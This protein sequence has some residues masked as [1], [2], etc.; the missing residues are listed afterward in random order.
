MGGDKRNEEKRDVL[1]GSLAK[2]GIAALV[3]SRSLTFTIII[4]S[5]VGAIVSAAFFFFSFLGM[6]AGLSSPFAGGGERG[7]G[8]SRSR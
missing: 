4:G 7:R 1:I 2:H 5:L 3:P 8:R 6:S